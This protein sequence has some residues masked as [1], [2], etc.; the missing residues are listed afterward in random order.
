MID[1]CQAIGLVPTMCRIRNRGWIAANLEHISQLI[2]AGSWLSSLDLLVRLIA[3]PLS[4][5][6]RIACPPPPSGAARRK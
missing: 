2:K 4:T 1:P 6:R 3:S 5:S